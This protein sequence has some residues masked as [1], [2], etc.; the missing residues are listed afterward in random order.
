MYVWSMQL[1]E[2]AMRAGLVWLVFGFMMHDG[3]L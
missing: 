3:S 1:Y 2:A